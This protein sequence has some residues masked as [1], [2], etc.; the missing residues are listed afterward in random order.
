VTAPAPSYRPPC[1]C[2]EAPQQYAGPPPEMSPQPMPP[3]F[4]QGS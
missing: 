1:G 4:R 2:E 3:R